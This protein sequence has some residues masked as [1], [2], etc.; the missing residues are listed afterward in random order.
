M[1]CKVTKTACPI[2]K[3]PFAALNNKAKSIMISGGVASNKTLR[4]NL[5]LYAKK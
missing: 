1:S 2:C 4:K 5:N 3:A